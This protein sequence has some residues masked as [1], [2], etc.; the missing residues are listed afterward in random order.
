MLQVA[1]VFPDIDNRSCAADV[2][3]PIGTMTLEEVRQDAERRHIAAVLAETN[4]HFQETAHRLGISR[5]TLW[6]RMQKLG[7]LRDR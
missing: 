6:E 7:L 4:G 5:T 3:K 2:V 1:D